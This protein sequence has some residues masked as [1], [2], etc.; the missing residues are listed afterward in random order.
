MLYN[1]TIIY[2]PAFWEQE[3]PVVDHNALA[4]L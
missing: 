4:T 3:D 1:L 2:Q